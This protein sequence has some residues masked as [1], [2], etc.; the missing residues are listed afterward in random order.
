MSTPTTP[1]RPP[2]IA[3][4]DDHDVIHAG[5][6]AWCALAT[7]PIQVVSNH[8]TGESLLAAH[9][10]GDDGV[11]AVV[12]DLELRS[13]QPDFDTVAAI[14]DAGHRVVVYS[15]L[16]NNEIIL[17]CLD[18]GAVTY[19][20][21]TEG[22]QHLVDAIRAAST[23]EP[24]VGPRMAAAILYDT[25]VGRPNLSERERQVLKAWFQTENKE[26]VGRRLHLAPGTIKT[27]LQRIRAKYAAVGRPATTKAKL[28]ARA[29]QDGIIGIEEL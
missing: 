17:Q 16:E 3:V 29:M 5:V 24:Y 20:A 4:V 25:T 11:S 27:H 7:P 15:H 18:I 9:P 28:V 2:S 8:L 21:K 14:V 12:L 10:A 13:R 26:M 6:G 23:D 22:Q 19:L 1:P